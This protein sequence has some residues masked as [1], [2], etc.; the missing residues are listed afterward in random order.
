MPGS[1]KP[2]K[3][4]KYSLFGPKND[5]FRLEPDDLI[6]PIIEYVRN[7]ADASFTYHS[8]R[9]NFVTW[10]VLK[11]YACKYEGFRAR[12]NER[13][14]MMLGEEMLD[15]FRMLYTMGTEKV[16][17]FK[18]TDLFVKMRK[19]I[20]HSSIFTS[21]G[22]YTHCLGLVLNYLPSQETTALPFTQPIEDIP[23]HVVRCSYRT[24]MLS[25]AKHAIVPRNHFKLV[26]GN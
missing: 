19:Y 17:D 21:F 16:V 6:T 5:P 25:L 4:S 14:H 26:T 22:T 15:N 13:L 8:L 3:Q 2:Y 9:H 7:H 24:K 23:T 1:R 18:H 11:F 20:G 12:L 10:Q